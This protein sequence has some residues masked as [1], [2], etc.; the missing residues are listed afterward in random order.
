MILIITI[1]SVSRPDPSV[2]YLPRQLV[3]AIGAIGA[4]YSRPGHDRRNIGQAGTVSGLPPAP[5]EAEKRSYSGSGRTLLWIRAKSPRCQQR[6]KAA[7]IWGSN[8]LPDWSKISAKAFS[9]ARAER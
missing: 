6:S 2:K 1:M 7:T 3:S 8:C 5:F 4:Q 9:K